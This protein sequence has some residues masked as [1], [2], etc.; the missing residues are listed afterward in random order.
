M[1]ASIFFDTIE[2]KKTQTNEYLE[3]KRE[4]NLPSYLIYTHFFMNLI[5]DQNNHQFKY[6]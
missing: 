2:E 1:L 5:M 4:I 6:P 3:K